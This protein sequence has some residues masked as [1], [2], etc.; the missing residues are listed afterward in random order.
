MMCVH[1]YAKHKIVNILYSGPVLKPKM[2]A[3]QIHLL[4]K[5][6]RCAQKLNK[7]Q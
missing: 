6:M 4:K 1:S 7:T 5:V 2:A 3:Q